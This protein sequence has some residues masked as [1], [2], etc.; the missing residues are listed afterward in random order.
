MKRLL[1]AALVAVAC[2]AQ[3]AKTAENYVI[4]ITDAVCAPLEATG[5][6]YVDFVCAIAEGVEGV[7][8][9]LTPG[10]SASATLGPAQMTVRVPI[11]G[12]AAFAAK[13]TAAAVAA[14]KAA[15]KK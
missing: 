5:L 7:V 1:M 15:R 2:T 8:T 6:P 11:A 4:D 13:H 12:A 9:L 3:E 14:R 10:V